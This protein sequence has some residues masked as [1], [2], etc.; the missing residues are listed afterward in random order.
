MTPQGKMLIGREAASGSSTPI[1]AVNPATGEQLA[2]TYAG[3][4]Q[5]EVERACELAEA[6]FTTYRETTLEARA[7]FLETVATE[8]EAIGDELIE[9]AIAET[10]LPRARLEGERGRTCGQLRLFAS[11]VRAGEWLDLRLDPALP[12]R[13]PIPRAD[14][15]QRHIPLGPVAVF[16]ASNFPLA[17]SVAGGDTASALAAGCPVIVKGHSA[18]PGTSE[19]VGRAVQ[20]A[21]EKRDLPE[22]VFS[23]LFGSGSE[24]GQ[25]LVSDPRIQA[26]GFT[27]SRG[28]GTALM[29]TAQARPQPIPVYAEMSSINPVFLL[30][31]A[32]RAR[33][34]K[35]A[36]GFVASLN[37]GAGQFCTNP[38]LVIAVKGPELSAFVE[39]AADA[40]KASAAQTM[41][42]P[43]IHAAYEQGVGRLSSND[44][45]R[46]VARGQAGE[47]AHPC[48]AGLYVTAAGDFLADTELQ[49]EVFGA[50]SLVIECAD[51]HEMRQVA[52]QLEGQ[53][54]ATLQMD[55]ADLDAAKALLPILERKAG[56]ILANGWPTGVEVCHAMVHGGPYPA[57]SDSRTTSVGSAAIFRFLRPVCYQALPQGLL[58]EALKDGNPWKVSRL[59][60]GKREA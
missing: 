13:E 12:E 60:D 43:G 22:G 23:L 54:T 2:P 18:H 41:L 24:I 53:L 15:R 46:E 58:P 20:R 11:V 28:G 14:L 49:E 8:I 3:G 37:M 19:L 39:A 52:S 45:V 7:A 51:Q 47:S 6:A 31:E 36:E 1:H 34:A 29:K 44:K 25:A 30:P 33:G 9:R 38:G 21:V 50:T 16:G 4:T 17:F 48:Q 59:V 57:T 5:A 26:V 40:V 55:D 27:G 35:I 56:R 42:T 32:L 10:G